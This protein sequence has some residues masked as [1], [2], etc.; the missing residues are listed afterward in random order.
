M[1]NAYFLSIIFTLLFIH[2]NVNAQVAKGSGILK[3]EVRE[4]NGISEI[5]AQGKFKLFLIHGENEGVK[6]EA[7]DNLIEYFQTRMD[8]EVLYI[9][10]GAEIRK[11][12]ELNV[13]VTINS[14][15]KI[16]LLNEVFLESNGVLQF[17]E[18]SVFAGGMSR[19]NIEIFASKTTIETNDGTYAYLKGYSEKLFVEVHDETEI[20]AFNLQAD[21]C[22]VKSSGL[23]DVM[24]N[25][26][27]DLKLLVTGSS[28]VYYTGN[29]KISKRIF[30]SSGFI[31]K[32]KKGLAVTESAGE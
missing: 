19:V 31:V 16:T 3:E 4:F 15:K 5:I 22:Q 11:F 18:L 2:I 28:N 17:E 20:N 27:K 8:G 12:K 10:M 30:A 32:R 23:T 29:P 21:Y 25:V 14:L 9:R 1:K 13:Y 26:E 24:V 6:V 7:D